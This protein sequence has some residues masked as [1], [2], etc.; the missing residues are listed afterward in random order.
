MGSY[1]PET[2]R[3]KETLPSVSGFDHSHG[4]VDTRVFLVCP[5]KLHTCQT[6]S[7]EARLLEGTTLLSAFRLGLLQLCYKWNSALFIL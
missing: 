7:P 5:L 1:L 2:I 4:T 3:L 6:P